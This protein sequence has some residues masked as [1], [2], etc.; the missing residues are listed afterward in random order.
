MM[1]GSRE[2]F[3]YA[4]CSTCGGLQ[5]IEIPS[6]LAR[7]Y[8]SS[9]Y[10]MQPGKEPEPAKGLKG[11]LTRWYCRSA[12]LRPNVVAERL[13]RNLLPPPY[14]FLQV[15]RYLIEARLHGTDARILDVGCGASPSRLAAIQRCG[16]TAVEG[17]DPFIVEDADYYGVPLYRRTLAEHLGLY[18]LVMFHHSLEHVP[19][20]FETLRHAARL[21]RV[22]GTCLVRI[23][24]MGTYHWQRFGINWVET[25]APRHLHLMTTESIRLLARRVGLQVLKTIW[26]STPLELAASVRYERG[27]SLRQTPRITDGFTESE[28]IV[29]TQQTHDLNREGNA[30]RA[31]F[32]LGHV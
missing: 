14:D 6:D 5:I 13:V 19:D 27:I 10:S 17:L 31:C 28:M 8:P 26:D 29:F 4:R 20:P 7:H 30:G 24:V 16:F 2:M 32:Y 11:M 23:P 12:I 25:D 1:Y 3:D 21:L 18:D 22:G 9:Y 15:G